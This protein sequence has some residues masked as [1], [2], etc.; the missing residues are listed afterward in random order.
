MGVL[1]CGRDW[2]NRGCSFE[3]SD[4]PQRRLPQRLGILHDVTLA[5]A[6]GTWHPAIQRGDQLAQVVD[7]RV[8]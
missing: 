1:T 8:I 7:K 4:P 2:R 5:V 3:L 6:L